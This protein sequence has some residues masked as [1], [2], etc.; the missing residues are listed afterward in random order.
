MISGFPVAG[1]GRPVFADVNGDKNIDVL[2]LT[3][4][5]KIVGWNLR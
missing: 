4:D 3:M 1:W 2:A 5:K